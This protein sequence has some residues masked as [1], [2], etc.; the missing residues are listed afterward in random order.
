MLH[1]DKFQAYFQKLNIKPEELSLELV[2]TL[3]TQHL[4]NFT[5]NNMAVLL[6]QPISLNITQIINKIVVDNLGGYCF[7]HN[8]LMH[9]VLE[10][11]GFTVRILI[12]KVINN[13]DIDTPRTHR[14][15]LLI[16]NNEKYLIDVGFG[17]S[18]PQTPIKIDS[19]DN[20]GN[21]R[22]MKNK[23][24]DYQLEVVRKKGNFS[25]YTFNLANYTHADCIMGNYY[26][27]NHPDA[28][29]VNNLLVS[30]IKPDI[31]LSLRNT[32]YQKISKDNT[33]TVSINND[34]Q[35]C[36]IINTD[37]NIPTTQEECKSLFHIIH[38]K[39]G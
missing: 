32:T 3:Q 26:S 17:S 1:V 23:N 6:K 4:Q 8:K 20:Q 34:T 10:S 11:L 37:F 2:Q 36:S 30:L 38:S 31:T 24:D 7:E 22:I 35:L 14:I 15:T 27:S 18:C 25:L 12:A 13:Q 28:V 21:Y 33:E 19:I 39:Q 29:F 5:F 9:D 16:F